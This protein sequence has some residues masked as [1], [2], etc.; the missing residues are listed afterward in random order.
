MSSRTR[1]FATSTSQLP[2]NTDTSVHVACKDAKKIT[3]YADTTAGILAMVKPCGIICAINEMYTCESLSQVFSFLLRNLEDV[4][5]IK[6]I[7]YDRACELKPFLHNL[8]SKENIGAE[9][10]LDQLEFL[11]DIFHIHGHVSKKCMPLEGNKHCEF[12]PKL[13][14]FA[15]IH[16]ANT[17]VAEQV[18]S[19]LGKFKSNVRKMSMHKFRFFIEDIIASKN[20]V[21]E[22]RLM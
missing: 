22:A 19:W 5:S 20:E 13:P 3:K 6:F 7:G 9:I 2:D 8:K 17:E 15:E 4:P 18:F 16:G 21:L 10:L 12:H 14:R 11:V 1:A